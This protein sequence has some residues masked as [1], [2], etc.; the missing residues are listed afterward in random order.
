MRLQSRRSGAWIKLKCGQRQEFVI[1][2]YT[3]PQGARG[4]GSLLLGTYDAGTASC[5]TPATSAAA[6]TPLRCALKAQNGQA[7]CR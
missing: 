2:G 3:D 7:A 5:N 1:G 4:F 6:S